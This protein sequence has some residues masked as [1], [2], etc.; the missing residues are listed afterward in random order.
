MTSAKEILDLCMA[1]SDS[2]ERAP[3]GANGA[4]GQ[5]S[6]IDLDT[7]KEGNNIHVT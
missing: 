1:I 4:E 7:Q 3:T 2:K 6:S 5:S